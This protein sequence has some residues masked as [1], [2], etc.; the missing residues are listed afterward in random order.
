VRS[1]EPAAATATRS[2]GLLFA[3]GTLMRGFPLHQLLSGR[4]EYIARGQVRARLIDLGPYPGAVPDRDAIV[5]GEMYRVV[6]PTLWAAL[7]SAEGPQ[8]HRREVTVRSEDGRERAASIYWY[9]G[10]LDR[11]G[12][13]PGGDYRAHAPATSIYHQSL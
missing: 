13:I 4:A 3:Y 6:D 1:K 12:P 11:G 10:P 2:P 5:A 9:I 7:D 8:Y